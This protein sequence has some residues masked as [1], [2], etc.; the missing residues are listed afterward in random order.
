[1]DFLKKLMIGASF[2]STTFAA[3]VSS[4]TQGSETEAPAAAAHYICGISL[5]K[6]P[7]V[8][9]ALRP[10]QA[11]E[12]FANIVDLFNKACS[13]MDRAG[14]VEHIKRDSRDF[15]LSPGVIDPRL[16]KAL[17]AIDALPFSPEEKAKIRERTIRNQFATIDAKYFEAFL[18]D[19][20]SNPEPFVRPLLGVLSLIAGRGQTHT[21]CGAKDA[22]I[23]DEVRAVLFSIFERERLLSEDSLRKLQA[24]QDLASEVLSF[25]QANPHVDT[26]IIGGSHVGLTAIPY[27]PHRGAL[28]VNLDP[29][30]GADVVAPI[31]D[32]LPHL[33]AGQFSHVIDDSNF[34]GDLLTDTASELFRVLKSGGTIG[35]NTHDA[36]KFLID[37]GFV[38]RF[39]ECVDPDQYI[40][41]IGNACIDNHDLEGLKGFLGDEFYKKLVE[42]LSDDLFVANLFA[43]VDA[44]ELPLT[45]E[46]KSSY[47]TA[48]RSLWETISDKAALLHN[49]EDGTV[50][51]GGI[52]KVVAGKIHL[53]NGFIKP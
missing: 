10:L 7:Q 9:E 13:S 43:E 12:K 51:K 38:G 1:M 3:D 16:E 24:P 34:F 6:L 2:V 35:D 23:S 44:A 46:T 39:K 28:V 32:V 48:Y 4:V 47:L 33:L 53:L 20:R 45:E 49:V 15:L 27:D 31:A 41:R 18:A 21:G 36:Y 52:F 37:A 30:S 14:R 11:D 8:Q 50:Y 5:D 19:C 17:L 40:E 42:R 22:A 25:M 26:L 29:E